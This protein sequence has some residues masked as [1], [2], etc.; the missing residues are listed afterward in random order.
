MSALFALFPPSECITKQTCNPQGRNCQHAFYLGD[1][2][3]PAVLSCVGTPVCFCFSLFSQ[4]HVFSNKSCCKLL[5]KPFCT[6][7]FKFFVL[8]AWD[9]MM[10]SFLFP[11]PYFFNLSSPLSLCASLALS[12]VAQSL[13]VPGKSPSKYGRR[14]SAIGIGT[15]EEV[16]VYFF[17]SCL[18]FMSLVF[19]LLFSYNVS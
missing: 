15:I 13:L 17:P 19:T 3:C 2:P 10:C 1:T 9:L 6:M 5:F 4:Y 16:H 7:L 12:C 8:C 11:S 14:G 18:L